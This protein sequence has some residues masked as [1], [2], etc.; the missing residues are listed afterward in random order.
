MCLIIEIEMPGVPRSEAGSLRGETTKRGL[1]T[2][3][4]ERQPRHAAG[5]RFLLSEPNEGCACSLLGENADWD[6]PYYQLNPARMAFLE[7]TL[8]FVAEKAG[9]AGFSLRAVWL[10]GAL[11]DAA[12]AKV[13]VARLGKLLEDVR[14]SRLANNV[15]Y[16]IS[17]S[18]A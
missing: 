11:E 12:A 6:Q 16:K 17:A 18:A 2:L 10:E 7:A 8:R 9:V 5:S 13:R 1:L 4:A 15:L 14:A 3:S